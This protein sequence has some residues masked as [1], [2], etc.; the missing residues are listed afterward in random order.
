MLGMLN[1]G[2]RARFHRDLAT[3]NVYASNY[4]NIAFE[5]RSILAGLRGWPLIIAR[6]DWFQ[7]VV[8]ARLAQMESANKSKTIMAYSYAA[9]E[10]FKFARVRGW[11]TVLGQIDAGLSE[12]RI[13]ARLYQ[14]KPDYRSGWLR[15]P[16][17]YWSNWH[18]ECALADRI[19]VN[20]LWSRAALAGEGVPEAKIKVVPLAY[21]APKAL[22]PFER[23]YPSAFTTSRPLRVLFLGQLN[24]RKGLGPLLEAVRLLRGEPIEFSL[25]GPIQIVIPLDLRNNQQI[26]WAGPVS[27]ERTAGFYR[28]ADI[29]IFPT[30]SDGFGLT[31]LEA[32]AWKLPIITTKFC[33][34][35]VENGKN[36]FI[37]PEV[38][39]C[40]IAATLRRLV[41]DPILVQ[42]L[43]D[44]AVV[45]Q[46]HS[47]SR[48]GKEWLHVFD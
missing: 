19:V 5:L 21:D 31:Q 18:E 40:A 34:E 48:V 36:G 30:Y 6:N 13:V 43:S 28:D 15:A 47:I 42:T 16:L 9:L 20:S 1:P 2:L 17:R 41:E 45:A 32:L 27:Y 37:L 29:F 7:Q 4:A 24:L 14:E 10:I 46:A 26:H 38:T 23:K 22:D 35:V 44:N 33:G 25:V 3:A 39:P 8:V 12:E 11:R